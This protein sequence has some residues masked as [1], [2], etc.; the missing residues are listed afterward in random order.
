MI[1]ELFHWSMIERPQLDAFERKSLGQA[2]RITRE[3]WL[4]EVFG[5]SIA[6][7]HMGHQFHYVPETETDSSALPL[8][9]A[10]VGRQVS[11]KENDPPAEGL[12]EKH[13]DAWLASAIIM[14]P[15]H[16][17]HG[18]RVAMQYHH[19]IGKPM[20]LLTSLAAHINRESPPEPYTLSVAPIIDASTFWHFVNANKNAV[21]NVTFDLV[22][23][24]MFDGPENM[25]K[26]LKELRDLERAR[27]IRLELENP[28]SLNLETKRIHGI[29]D[30]AAQGGGDI[31]ARA[32]GKK[33]YSSK[34]KIKT[35]QIE[36]S[37][38]NGTEDAVNELL[39]NAKRIIFEL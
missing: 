10:R 6:F 38:K 21:T 1:F 15:T 3:N 11:V 2:G 12:H 18:Q 4:R 8:M 17:E 29:V 20:A 28:D 25:D 19:D 31:E 36:E 23:P 9:M 27:K 37:E 39:A 5:K 14:D 35:M 26:E 13:R 34:R 16:H 32:K 7:A 22:P 24:N 30:Y 33:R